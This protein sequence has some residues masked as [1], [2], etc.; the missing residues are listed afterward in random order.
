MSRS[1][2]IPIQ[3]DYDVESVKAPVLS[4]IRVMTDHETL[5]DEGDDAEFVYEIITGAIKEYATLHDGRRQ[6]TRFHV[7]GD[8]FGFSENGVEAHSAEAMGRTKLRC[9][10]YKLYLQSASETPPRAMQLIERLTQRQIEAEERLVM[11]GCMSALQ[12]VAR[13]LSSLGC[14]RKGEE[15]VLI[16]SRR[17]IA[18]HLGLTPET[19]CRCIAELKSAGAIAMPAARRMRVLAPEI[20][21]DYAHV[22]S[23]P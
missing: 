6:I 10:P 9:Y 8:I 13:F 1:D 3:G 12:R 21:S 5:Y 22:N 18:E 14:G 20:L 2:I 23:A 17:D 16:M 7:S 19:V 11:L 15:V 4:S